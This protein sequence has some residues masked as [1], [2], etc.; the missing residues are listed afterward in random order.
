MA[1][2]E[3]DVL[4]AARTVPGRLYYAPA[5]VPAAAVSKAGYFLLA[6]DQDP[7]P[8]PELVVYALDRERSRLRPHHAYDD[9]EEGQAVYVLTTHDQEG[10]KVVT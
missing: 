8:F 2:P 10:A 5:P 3:N 1:G 9:M 6:Y 7:G 4:M